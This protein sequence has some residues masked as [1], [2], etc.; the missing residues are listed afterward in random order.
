MEG[1]VKSTAGPPELRAS[2]P[3]LGPVLEPRPSFPVAA[4]A[5]FFFAPPAGRH[6]DRLR[7]AYVNVRMR[8][9]RY[10]VREHVKREALT[11]G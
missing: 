6:K 4:P 7:S 5:R 3:S 11:S 10:P 8:A 1:G 2:L 9:A